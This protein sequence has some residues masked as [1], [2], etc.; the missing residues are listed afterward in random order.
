VTLLE[1]GHQDWPAL[2]SYFSNELVGTSAYS[3]AIDTFQ[4]RLSELE[5]DLAACGEE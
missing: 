2:R 4:R 3:Q 1:D 5:S